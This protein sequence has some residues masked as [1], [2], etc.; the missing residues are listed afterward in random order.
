MAKRQNTFQELLATVTDICPVSELRK[1]K[2]DDILHSNL[3]KEIQWVYHGLGGCLETV[4]IRL[5][6]W[7]LIVSG[8]AVELDEYLHFNRYR[9]F[10]LDSKLYCKLDGFPM[11]NYRKFCKNYESNCLKAGSYGRKWTNSSC[12]R[13]FGK[14]SSPPNLSNGGAPRWKQRAFYDYIKDLS[15]L[16]V[17][18]KVARISIWDEI[19]ID[20]ELVTISD[21]LDKRIEMAA[22]TIHKLILE[23][24]R[25]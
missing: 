5:G 4:P 10:T 1:P 21:V 25:I 16:I 22:N 7:D 9:R 15:P 23:R 2:L 24:S 3:H 14:H 20:G 13:Q 18:T 8:I 6:A 11:G 17:G 12:E 19:A